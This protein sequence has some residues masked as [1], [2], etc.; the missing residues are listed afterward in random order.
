MQR[1][2]AAPPRDG[3]SA[4][5]SAGFPPSGAQ[6]GSA[7][8]RRASTRAF[9]QP[10]ESRSATPPTPGPAPSAP[11]NDTPPTSTPP[12]S[13]PP[14]STPPS[15]FGPGPSAGAAS[16]SSPAPAPSEGTTPGRRSAFGAG[17]PFGAPGRSETQAGTTPPPAWP[18]ASPGPGGASRQ[19]SGTDGPA[20]PWGSP[21]SGTGAAP[22]SVPPTTGS[23]FGGLAA[24]P[25]GPAG[26][27]YLEDDE[28]DWDDE[29]EPSYTWL[30][31]IILVVVAFVLGLLIWNL[32]LSPPD[33][34]APE[35]ASAPVPPTPVATATTDLGGRR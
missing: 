12:A 2:D 35:E 13:T 15:P 30:H 18:S 34:F 9:G 27:R 14:A 4:A 24:Q 19:A 7:T 10:P 16:G 21:S 5:P 8:P 3:S 32:V 20:L 23:P 17:S 6:G 33:D 31:Y 29:H 22:A 28:E 1:N 11:R 26:P 25:P